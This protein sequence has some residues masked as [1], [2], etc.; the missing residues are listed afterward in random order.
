MPVEGIDPYYV[1]PTAATPPPEETPAPP[2]EPEVITEEN[3]G[4]T[5]DTTA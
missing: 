4:K 1:T 5:I 3:T 2:P